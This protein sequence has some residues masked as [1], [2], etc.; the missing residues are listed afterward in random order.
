MLATAA[1][2]R[3]SAE[4]NLIDAVEHVGR[5]ALLVR[6]DRAGRGEELEEQLFRF[7]RVL[8]EEP[9]LTALL[10]D[11]SAPAQ[12]RIALVDKVLSG[13]GGSVDP[14]AATLLANTQVFWVALLSALPCGLLYA[15]LAG[16]DCSTIPPAV[17]KSLYKHV[18]TDLGLEAFMKDWRATGQKIL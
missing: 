10:S 17:F 15:A 16:A 11:Y 12:G 1:S 4:S 2:Q 3:W 9:R 14:T 8:D 18:L 5:L 13:G 6:A 7:G